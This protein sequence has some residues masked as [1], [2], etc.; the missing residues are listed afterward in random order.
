M[1]FDSLLTKSDHEEGAE[2]PVLNP[3]TGED[4][5]VKIKLL[6]VDSSTYQYEY[7][8]QYNKAVSLM[9]DKKSLSPESEVEAEIEQ[10]AAVT[11]GWSGVDDVEFSRE[12]CIKLYTESPPVRNQVNRFINNRKN[13]TKG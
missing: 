1:K 11:I 8:R 13:F 5:G 10:L 3:Q 6:G 9:A 7:K 4:T 2:M 12:A